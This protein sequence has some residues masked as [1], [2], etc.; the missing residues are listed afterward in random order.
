MIKKQISVVRR[1]ISNK[2]RTVFGI[3]RRK[4]L[5]KRQFLESI[6]QEQNTNIP[7]EE[8]MIL[9]TNTFSRLRTLW[10]DCGSEAVWQVLTDK[11]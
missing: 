7:R 3:E 4:N 11:K 10:K 8:A 9:I 5:P 6:F 1:K 2:V